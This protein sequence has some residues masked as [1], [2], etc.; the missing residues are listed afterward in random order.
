MAPYRTRQ[1]QLPGIRRVAIPGEPI[2]DRP[3]VSRGHQTGGPR[4]V[5]LVSSGH[6]SGVTGTPD[7]KAFDP[8]ALDP[9]PVIHHGDAAMNSLPA[10]LALKEQ[11]RNELSEEEWGLWVRPMLLLKVMAPNTNDKTLLAA[12]PSNSQIQA[13][14][15]QYL[16]AMCELLEPSGFSIRLTTYPSEWEIEESRKR[17]GSDM[18]PK[19][20]TRES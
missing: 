5:H 18:A 13:A 7:S 8:K 12:L 11:L 3:L 2:P 9:K 15:K 10:W 4:A 16:P 1:Q 14:A 20:W 17:Y 6:Q 19:P